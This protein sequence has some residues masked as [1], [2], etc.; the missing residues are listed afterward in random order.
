MSAPAPTLLATAAPALGLLLV[1][2]YLLRPWV[3]RRQARR[4]LHR[5][6]QRLGPEFRPDL[7]LDNG[8]D[9]LAFIDFAVLTPTGIAIVDFLPYDGAIFGAEQAEQ[10]V[11][12]VGR[13]TTRFPNPLERNREHLSAAR[14][15]FEKMPLR[16]LVLFG[17][18]ASFPKG[19]PEG[20][21]VPADL[22]AEPPPLSEVPEALRNAWTELGALADANA[23]RYREELRLSRS[24]EGRARVV[25]GW[26]LGVAAVLWAAAGAATM[27]L[28]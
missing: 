18:E 23:E 4:R 7:I 26:L 15:N 11:Q 2:V 3:R 5:I 22:P 17:P 28:G 25:A 27:W 12:V 19:R 13:K 10:W 21:V 16:G 1:A 8:I 24:D 14:Y 9:G 6:L 20:A